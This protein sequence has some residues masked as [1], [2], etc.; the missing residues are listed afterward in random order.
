M[1]NW[2]ADYTKLD[3]KVVATYTPAHREALVKELSELAGGEELEDA[4][5][6]LLFNYLFNFV[7]PIGDIRLKEIMALPTEEARNYALSRLIASSFVVNPT[8]DVTQRLAQFPDVLK[9]P[10]KEKVKGVKAPPKAMD[11]QALIAKLKTKQLS[12][13]EC[14]FLAKIFTDEEARLFLPFDAKALREN[15][16]SFEKLF[17]PIKTFFD[18][19]GQYFA[20]FLDKDKKELTDA[21]GTIDPKKQAAWDKEKRII[22]TNMTLLAHSLIQVGEFNLALKL[23]ALTNFQKDQKLVIPPQCRKEYLELSEL[24]DSVNLQKVREHLKERAGEDFSYPFWTLFAADVDKYKQSIA[25]L[26][27]TR[28]SINE[29]LDA[30]QSA[31]L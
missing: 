15:P 29:N 1:K 20:A 4:L 18:Q 5:S 30:A 19:S 26:S 14:Q 2:P 31:K 13:E 22:M 6:H 28:E 3:A 21:S 8:V 24:F 12:P 11:S 23:Y 16:K 9:A 25:N 10:S 17:A 27:K 7:D